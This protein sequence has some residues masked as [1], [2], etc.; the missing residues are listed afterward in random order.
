MLVSQW[1]SVYNLIENVLLTD[2]YMITGNLHI[3]SGFMSLIVPV[4][5][6]IIN[7][8]KYLFVYST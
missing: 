8:W 7:E 6:G 1:Q 4:D 2:K 3:F 5:E